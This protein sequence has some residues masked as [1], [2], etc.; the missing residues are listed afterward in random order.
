MTWNKNTEPKST[1][2]YLCTCEEYGKR[3]V[4]PLTR[5]EYPKGNFYWSGLNSG[6]IVACAK[7]PKPYEGEPR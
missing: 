7:F 2:W 4:M 1:G 3:W 6:K 5:C